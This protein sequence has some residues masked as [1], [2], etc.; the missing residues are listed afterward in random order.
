MPVTPLIISFLD[1]FLLADLAI[2]GDFLDIAYEQKCQ[3]EI[4]RQTKG[5]KIIGIALSRKCEKRVGK[6]RYW[7]F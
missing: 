7:L 6:M 1:F 5:S 3:S 4:I 2:G